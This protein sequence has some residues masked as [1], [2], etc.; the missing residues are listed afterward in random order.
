MTQAVLKRAEDCDEL[1]HPFESFQQIELELILNL[2]DQRKQVLILLDKT[3]GTKFQNIKEKLIQR[4]EVHIGTGLKKRN[5]P[6]YDELLVHILANNFLEGIVEIIR[7]YK[8]KEWA[9]KM[10]E[11]V[12]KYYYYGIDALLR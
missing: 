10:L 7:H 4:I 3:S 11:L 1:Q 6:E 9:V 2:F 8:D 12:V 5:A